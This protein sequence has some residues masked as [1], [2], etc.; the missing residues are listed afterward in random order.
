MEMKEAI[1][2]LEELQKFIK[3]LKTIEETKTIQKALD[4]AFKALAYTEFMKG[5]HS[6]N[7]CAGAKE[8]GIKPGLGH[9]VRINCVGWRGEREAQWIP[10]SE[11]LPKENG[12]YL[13]STMYGEVYLDA[14]NGINWERSEEILAWMPLPEPYKRRE[15]K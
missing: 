14:W 3:K 1:E 2:I 4:E 7:D 8:C 15:T 9:V 10:I 11:R 5:Q 13:T 6:C 12:F